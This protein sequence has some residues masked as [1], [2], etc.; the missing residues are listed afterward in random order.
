MD[1]VRGEREDEQRRG[2]KSGGERHLE[3]RGGKEGPEKKG[4]RKS[5]GE[6]TETF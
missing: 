6:G 2:G 4:G 3:M 1:E 5:R